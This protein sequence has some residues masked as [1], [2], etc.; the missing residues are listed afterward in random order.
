MPLRFVAPVFLLERDSSGAVFEGFEVFRILLVIFLVVIFRRVEFHCR[1]NL[2]YDRF[3][4]FPGVGQLLL[5]HFRDLFFLIA[6]IKNRGPVTWTD[7][8]ELA[9]GL[10]RIDLLPVDVEQLLVRN[11]GRI[12][13]DLD[14]F[15][16][17]GPLRTDQFVGR[18]GFCSAAV[19]YCRLNYTRRFVEGRLNAPKTTTGKNRGFRRC[20]LGILRLRR[21]SQKQQ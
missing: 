12:V 19:A 7:I 17:V 2:R 10:R 15:P 8:G 20:R 3:F 16:I 21:S 18:I 13:N 4:E 5:R 1:Q 14:R 9:V 6:A 11:F